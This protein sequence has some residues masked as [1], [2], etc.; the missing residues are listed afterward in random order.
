MHLCVEFNDVV[1]KANWRK[2]N[3]C[4]ASLG[5]SLAGELPANEFALVSHLKVSQL[6]RALNPCH[7][8]MVMQ[9]RKLQGTCLCI[10]A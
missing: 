2:M 5:L 7:P 1:S 8:K 4:K 6:N 10:K 9:K 3:V